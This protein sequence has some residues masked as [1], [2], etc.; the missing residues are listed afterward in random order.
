MMQTTGK[1]QEYKGKLEFDETPIEKSEECCLKYIL[2]EDGPVSVGGKEGIMVEQRKHG[3]H[4]RDLFIDGVA[5][6][7]SS[8]A[9][10]QPNVS[11]INGCLFTL[12]RY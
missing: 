12:Q 6:D 9:S 5:A 3:T 4:G 8:E 1:N 10:V 2:A 7:G 11:V